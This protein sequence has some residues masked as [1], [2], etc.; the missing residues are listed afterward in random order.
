M[1]HAFFAPVKNFAFLIIVAISA[2]AGIKLEYRRVLTDGLLVKMPTDFSLMDSQT[3]NS[4]Y[5]RTNVKPTEVYTNTSATVNISFKLTT[6]NVTQN[7]IQVYGNSLVEQLK[8]ISDVQIIKSQFKTINKEKAQIIEFYSKA[9]DG[10]IYNLLFVISNRKK[11]LICS[12]NCRADDLSQWQAIA[13]E[14]A[15][16]I[17]LN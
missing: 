10:Y 3:V 4:K 1:L 11:A 14:I 9:T 16:S 17:K 12:F 6:D 7:N 2:S 13:Y 8:K 5:G 15:T